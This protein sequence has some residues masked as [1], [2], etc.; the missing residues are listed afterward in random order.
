MAL[1][2]R[3]QKQIN[4]GWAQD[5]WDK[6]YGVDYLFVCTISS[7]LRTL[8]SVPSDVAYLDTHTHTHRQIHTHACTHT[9]YDC[10]LAVLLRPVL[11]AHRALTNTLS[12]NVTHCAVELCS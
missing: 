3:G 5:N 8:A 6:S 1:S 11:L 9:K 4:S 7:S 10:C 2:K 12:A